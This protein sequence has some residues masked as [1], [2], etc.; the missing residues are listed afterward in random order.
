MA[1]YNALLGA[2]GE[3]PG[4]GPGPSTIGSA[5]IL[6]VDRNTKIYYYFPEAIN[7]NTKVVNLASLGLGDETDANKFAI[8]ITDRSDDTWINDGTL[9]LG[10]NVFSPFA[11]RFN[12]GLSIND[13][14][15]TIK[16]PVCCAE[17]GDN[18]RIVGIPAYDVYYL[19]EVKD[20]RSKV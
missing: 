17:R 19:G 18:N 1:L 2:G 9:Q 16:P 14:M 5:K 12:N 6:S 4:P 10:M 3:Q 7:A 13:G 15:L 8:V 20:L 11:A